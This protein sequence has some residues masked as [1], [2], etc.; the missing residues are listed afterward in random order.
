M[1]NTATGQSI[2]AAFGAGDVPAILG[3]SPTMSTGDTVEF[4]TTWR[5]YSARVAG[6]L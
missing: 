3:S 2:Y 6:R 5:G 1:S 4:R